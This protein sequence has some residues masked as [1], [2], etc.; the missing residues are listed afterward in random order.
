MFNMLSQSRK[1][2][3]FVTVVIPTYNRGY[4]ISNAIDSVLNQSF[5]NFELIV[6]DDGSTDLTEDILK[7]YRDSIR[8]IRQANRGVSAARNAGIKA[9]RS[10]WIAFLDSDD[11][12]ETDKLKLQYEDITKNQAAVA[13]VVD[14]AL[15][16]KDNEYLSLFELRGVKKEYTARPFRPRPLI[17]V[18]TVNFYTQC[19]LIKKKAIEAAG[20]FN[21]SMKVS[22][23]TDLLFRVALE[24]P[25]IINPYLGTRIRRFASKDDALS[26]KYERDRIVEF[27]NSTQIYS[28]LKND[29]RL[30]AGERK[31]V[32]RS[33]GGLWCDIHNEYRH[34]GNWK[35]AMLALWRSIHEDPGFRSCVRALAKVSAIE[36]LVPVKLSSLRGPT[37]SQ[38]SQFK[39]T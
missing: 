33:L 21:E 6:V 20:L 5:K 32:C 22:E 17:D 10:E 30:T 9:A 2:L 19:S 36:A 23:D 1:N 37:R 16:C 26:L 13:H 3:P 14:A 34:Q 15:Q 38:R 27:I 4:C 18:M 31:K 7:H 29:P 28:N 39:R 12:W 8:L 11:I 35:P 25:F 24:G